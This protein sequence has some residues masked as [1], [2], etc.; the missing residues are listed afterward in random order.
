MIWLFG[1]PDMEGKYSLEGEERLPLRL[2]SEAL[3]RIFGRESWESEP[4][5][6]IKVFYN[7]F[8]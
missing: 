4:D 1:Q 6:P 3:V 7:F 8:I 5:K 2:V